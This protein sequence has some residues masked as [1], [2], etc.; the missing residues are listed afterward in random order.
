MQENRHVVDYKFSVYGTVYRKRFA[1]NISRQNLLVFQY[2]YDYMTL[3]TLMMVLLVMTIVVMMVVK[4]VMLMRM[5]YVVVELIDGTAELRRE[6][7]CRTGGSV[8]RTLD[9]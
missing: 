7:S 8:I 6:P 1:G 9:I 4:V 3:I 2:Q 5:R